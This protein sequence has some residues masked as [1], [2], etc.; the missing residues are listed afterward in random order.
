[1]L[2]RIVASV[3]LV[4]HGLVHLLYF[5]QSARFF[6]LKP[7]MIWP[8]GSWALSRILGDDGTRILASG[9][10]VF[11]AA[12]FIVGAAGLLSSQ[13]WWGAPVVASAVVSALLFLVYWNGQLQNI[14]GQGAVGLVLDAIILI[15]I[16]VFR[17]P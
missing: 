1:M 6:E 17:W 8:A 9:L 2:A 12:G 11:V 14:D 10:Y 4:L 16:L 7:G 15:T 13:A 5:A 3:F